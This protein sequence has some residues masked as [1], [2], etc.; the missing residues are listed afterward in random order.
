MT[1]LAG[2]ATE[3]VSLRAAID[4]ACAGRGRLVLISGPAGI[5]K[6]AL[7]DAALAM[8]RDRGMATARGRAIDDPG[9]PPLWPWTRLLRGWSE[10]QPLPVADA[11]DAHARF[12]LLET[13]VD[14]VQAH[15]D[16]DG[17]LIVL[18]DLHWADRLSV[19]A[20]R[21]LSSELDDHRLALVATYRDTPV[22]P[23]DDV[24]P[25]LLRGNAVRMIRLAGLARAEIAAWL[26]TLVGRVDDP[27]AGALHERTA[28]NPLLV[29]LVAEHTARGEELT[30]RPD[31]RRLVVARLAGFTPAARELLDLASVLG[32]RVPLEALAA[33]TGRDSPQ[34]LDLLAP[35]LADGV[36]RRTADGVRFEHALVRDAVYAE[37]KPSAALEAHRRCAAALA[38]LGADAAL[39]ATHWQRAGVADA[40]R[41]WAERADDE[42]RA[43]TAHEDAARFARLALDSAAGTGPAERARLLLRLAEAL[44]LAD[45]VEDALDACT[46]AA[47][48]A[49]AAGRP[50]LLAR[51]ALVVHGSGNPKIF[52][53]VPPIC[54]RALAR[55]PPDEFA[56]R[57]RL[58]AQ[59]AVAM[60]EREGGTG[61]AELASAA[62]AAAER[63]GDPAAE[64]DA[65]AA[66]HLAITGVET[67]AERLELGRRAIELGASGERPIGAL[68]GHLWR[69]DSSFQ[70]GNLAEMDREIDA[71]GHIARARCSHIARWHELRMR[72]ARSAQDGDFV[73]ARASNGQARELG[74]RLGGFALFGLTYAFSV[75]LAVTRGDPGEMPADWA[76]LISHGPPWPLVQ[77]THPTVHALQGRHELARAEFERF[78]DATRTVPKGVRWTGTMIQ[79]W[80]VAVLLEDAEVAADLYTRLG[81]V[82]H[83]YTGD[84]S[85]V[86][87]GFGSGSR[88][89]GDL[90]RVS[91]RP[92]DALAHYR[93]A[94]TMNLR[95]NARPQVSLSRLGH[96]QAL[97]ALGVS[98]DP[99]TDASVADLRDLAAAEF[100]RLDMPG[101][102]A[103]ARALKTQDTSPLTARENEVVALVAQSLTNREI[104]ARLFLSERT[105]ESHI[106]SILAKLSFTRRTEIV[107]WISRRRS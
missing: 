52:S 2:R 11:T 92:N 18:E 10:A 46:E 71:V 9:A 90:A 20:L 17:L 30:D 34:T 78:R 49:D 36:L 59:I 105:I 102:L 87:F 28:G 104:A 100:E 88:M 54:E 72:A 24:L 64:L 31:L 95:V 86:V 35:A 96:A 38:D 1:A 107:S 91:G 16:V 63:S 56:L 89:L 44:T 47:D 26:P 75:Q 8:A 58:L 80:H 99:E 81:D 55:L 42:A 57:S 25:D 74:H 83:Y 93:A 4:D 69:A 106:R 5:G 97:L 85:G 60:A 3:Q 43:A 82:G 67:V 22:G 7:A 68:W 61:P 32:E 39:V 103:T 15:A 14:V 29:R 27:L 23:L 65:I 21:H 50:D 37:I 48:L 70:L 98:R 51:A 19:L 62:L 66:R 40:C 84:G 76:E 94:T 13:V 41:A 6:S 53:V 77:L 45:R 33:L 73:A 101:P 79:L 12:R